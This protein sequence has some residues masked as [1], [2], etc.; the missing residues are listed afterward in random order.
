RT[1]LVEATQPVIRVEVVIDLGRESY[2]L[3]GDLRFP[4]EVD[5]RSV[6]PVRQGKQ[7]HEILRHLAFAAERDDVAGKCE[8]V[9]ISVCRGD[10][11]YG[12]VDGPD[13]RIGE[14]PG[15]LRG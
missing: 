7:I 2:R 9:D 6:T 12:V 5:R 11:S 4:D 8:M 13:A 3:K 15:F 1:K 14:I 10:T